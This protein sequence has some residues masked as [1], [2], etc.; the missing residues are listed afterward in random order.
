MHRKDLELP[1]F[2]KDEMKTIDWSPPA[3]LMEELMKVY[4][5]THRGF[6]PEYRR[7]T[8]RDL[9]Q[10]AIKRPLHLAISLTGE[11]LMYPY[12]DEVVRLAKKRDMTTFIVSNGTFPQRI[13]KMRELPTQ[14]YITLAGPEY[15]TWAQATNPLWNARE[16]WK[17]LNESLSLLPSLNTR[18]V[19]RITAIKRLNMNSPQKYAELI[20]NAE[21]NFISVKGFSHV[22]GARNRLS[23]EN[24]PQMEDIEIFAENLAEEISYKIEEEVERG[25]AI[26]LW[27]EKGERML[28]E[29][30]YNAR[31]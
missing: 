15:Q 10:D 9:W 7:K 22:G 6:A 25:R 26:L 5:G 30:T 8:E 24:Q 27:D 14:L 31:R 1:P 18:T 11:P 21:P 16:Q 17:K 29:R 12:I 23:K 4:K 3:K 20:K 13:E 19:I 28:R 2:K